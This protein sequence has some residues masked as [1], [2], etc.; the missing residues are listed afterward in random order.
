MS[1]KPKNDYERLGELVKRFVN[2][3]KPKRPKT[4]PVAQ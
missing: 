3:G 2:A 4:E 1:D